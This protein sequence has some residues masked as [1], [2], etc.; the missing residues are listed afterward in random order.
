MITMLSADHGRATDRLI[1]QMEDMKAADIARE[2]HDMSPGAAGR[3]R[4]RAG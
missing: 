4:L 2:L 1:A 3:G